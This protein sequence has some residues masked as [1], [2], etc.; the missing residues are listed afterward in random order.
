MKRESKSYDDYEEFSQE[1]IKIFENNNGH[2][3][4]LYKAPVRIGK[5]YFCENYLTFLLTQRNNKGITVFLTTKNILCDDVFSSINPQLESEYE[6]DRLILVNQERANESIRSLMELIESGASNLIVVTNYAYFTGDRISSLSALIFDARMTKDYKVD[7]ILDEAE[8][9]LNGFHQKLLISR[10]VSKDFGR[11]LVGNNTIALNPNKSRL[12]SNKDLTYGLDD[13]SYD[14]ISLSKMNIYGNVIAREANMMTFNCFQFVNSERESIKVDSKRKL[15]VKFG[16][17]RTV[18]NDMSVFNEI[19]VISLVDGTNE[20]EIFKLNN[21]THKITPCETLFRTI[22]SFHK[23]YESDVFFSLIC[24]ID[25]IMKSNEVYLHHKCVTSK[26][27]PLIPFNYNQASKT[28][29]RYLSHKSNDATYKLSEELNLP[30]FGKLYEFELKFVNSS[31]L[32]KIRNLSD[33]TIMLSATWNEWLLESTIDQ[34]AFYLKINSEEEP[35]EIK[36]SLL[37]LILLIKGERFNGNQNREGFSRLKSQ[38]EEVFYGFSERELLTS[39]LL[40]FEDQLRR[41][42]EKLISELED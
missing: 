23:R 40:R 26:N 14:K 33:N 18:F 30:M 38:V 36:K 25:L 7:F 5:T 10:P 41:D 4:N 8:S 15:C 12:G 34:S 21:I 29:A 19:E 17:N 20:I 39:L 32:S 16:T 31:P 3:N 9:F 35:N 28:Y 13:D 42:V 22:E 6:K 1:F 37:G 11:K 24:F 2:S 27:K